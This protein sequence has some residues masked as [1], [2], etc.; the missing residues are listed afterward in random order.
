M[1]VR[2]LVLDANILVRAV[3][4]RR[5]RDLII[6][7]SAETSLFAP[8]VAFIDA[9]RHLPVI[10]GRRG[11]DPR[12]ASDILDRIELF[13]HPLAL[14]IYIA[15]EYDSKR[16]IADRDADDWPVLTCALTLGCPIWTEDN[17]FFGTGVATWTTDR[18]SLYLDPYRPRP[19]DTAR[20]EEPSPSLSMRQ[21]PTDLARSAL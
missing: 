8:D 12:G 1:T 2:S 21:R 13:V 19:P 3:L 18:V 11:I 7:C 16:R 10:L 6:G 20:V 5:C 17:D 4:G 9:H 14:S 15:S